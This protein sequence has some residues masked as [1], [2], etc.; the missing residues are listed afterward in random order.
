ML[1][2]IFQELCSFSLMDN[3]QTYGPARKSNIGHISKVNLMVKRSTFL[4]VVQSNYSDLW[5]TL[6]MSLSV[7]FPEKNKERISKQ[8]QFDHS[9]LS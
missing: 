3:A 5:H 7:N 4:R 9:Y 2:L 1:C 6:K 8:T